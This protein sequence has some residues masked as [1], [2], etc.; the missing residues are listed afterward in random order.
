MQ[1]PGSGRA[2][3]AAPRAVVVAPRQRYP[4]D[5]ILET[6]WQWLASHPVA[7]P[8]AIREPESRPDLQAEP[9][10][11][12]LSLRSVAENMGTHTTREGAR[13]WGCGGARGESLSAWGLR[14][15][16]LAPRARGQRA[17][18]ER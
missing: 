9:R 17:A 3:A 4:L 5:K 15:R 12:N 18:R 13:A 14:A 11:H 2:S 1:E 8:F 7:D 16:A 10:E 6:S